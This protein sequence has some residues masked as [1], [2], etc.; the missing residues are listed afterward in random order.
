MQFAIRLPI[1]YVQTQRLPS[2]GQQINH[3][4]MRYRGEKKDVGAGKKQ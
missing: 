1:L 4:Y 3:T 2:S